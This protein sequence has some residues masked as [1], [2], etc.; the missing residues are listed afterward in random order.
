MIQFL[1]SSI[2]DQNCEENQI[3]ELSYTVYRVHQI[4]AGQQFRQSPVSG[5]G[6][7][8]PGAPLVIAEAKD[9]LYSSRGVS[10][11]RVLKYLYSFFPD[12]HIFWWILCLYAHTRICT[13]MK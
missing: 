12:V 1:S 9:N 7:P 3:P 8:P 11:H 5:G 10:R 6:W 4:S 2:G 13:Q